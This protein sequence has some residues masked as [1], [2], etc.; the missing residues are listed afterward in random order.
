MITLGT[1]AQLHILPGFG[2]LS[3]LNGLFRQCEVPIGN[4]RQTVSG[5]T[6]VRI[7]LEDFLIVVIGTIIDG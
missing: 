3:L 2:V 1:E 6:V 5:L 7:E 4:G